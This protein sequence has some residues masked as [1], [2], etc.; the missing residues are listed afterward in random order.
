M[1]IGLVS[2]L[3]EGNAI[4]Q[5]REN[6]YMQYFLSFKK[7]T[8]KAPFHPTLFVHFRKRISNQMVCEIIESVYKKAVSKTEE[9]PDKAD[10]KT[11]YAI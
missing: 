4:E 5:I 8:D 1:F 3:A 9:P 6:P 11:I 2:A 10:F 7:Y